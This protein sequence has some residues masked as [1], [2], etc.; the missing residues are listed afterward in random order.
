MG[1]LTRVHAPLREARRWD[2]L[3]GRSSAGARSLAGGAEH[4]FLGTPSGEHMFATVTINPLDKACQ[5]SLARKIGWRGGAG[6]R[7]YAEL[8]GYG[9]TADGLHETRPDP[10]GTA[11]A[12]AIASGTVPPTI[13][14][15][16]L[17]DGLA[18]DCV[19]GAPTAPGA[20]TVQLL[21]VWGTERG[22]GVLGAG[23][24]D[25]N[26][27]AEAALSLPREAGGR[28]QGTPLQEAAR[29]GRVWRR[30]L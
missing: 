17:D 16:H 2:Y 11:A 28:P 26:G 10:E 27:A 14:C 6:A 19:R 8:S 23:G 13:N 30:A 21:W 3:R 29:A 18:I 5:V 1:S 22:A 9:A 12:R 24:I 20:R 7:I 25:A 4:A 15:E